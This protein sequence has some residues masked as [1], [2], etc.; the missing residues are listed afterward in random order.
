MVPYAVLPDPGRLAHYADLG[1]GEGV[2]QLPRPVSRGA[3]DAGRVRG[4]LEARPR[5]VGATGGADKAS[6]P[7]GDR[8]RG[9]GPHAL[10][11]VRAAGPPGGSGINRPLRRIA[12]FC[13]LLVLALLLR[14]NWLQQVDRVELSGAEKNARV[15]F[16]RF[17]TPRGDIIVGGGGGHRLEGADSRDYTFRRTFKDAADVRAR[18]PATPP[19]PRA[20]RCWSGRTTAILSGQDDRFAFRHAKDVLTGSRGAAAA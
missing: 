20:P 13:G 19:R 1:I 12:I 14:A 9:H 3:A 8:V 10:S 6:L 2:L 7:P 5:G 15:R 4:V 17:A 18:A 16:E 11:G